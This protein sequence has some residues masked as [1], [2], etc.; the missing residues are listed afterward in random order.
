MLSKISNAI[1]TPR[2]DDT[3]GN[4]LSG[5][6]IASALMD[7]LVVRG[8]ITHF[9]A[10]GVLQRAYD[11]LDPQSSNPQT[12]SARRFIRTLMNGRYADRDPFT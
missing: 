9:E 7:L 12:V 6:L 8:L 10:K 4:E 11:A 3:E 1:A 5:G 2:H